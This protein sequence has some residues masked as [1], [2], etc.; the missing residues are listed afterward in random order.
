MHEA[1]RIIR[2]DGVQKAVAEEV[3]ASVVLS[4]NDTAHDDI[5]GI[6]RYHAVDEVGLPDIPVGLTDVVGHIE[7]IPTVG[8]EG[9]ELCD[10]AVDKLVVTAEDIHAV[11]FGV[12]DLRVAHP[13]LAVVQP[14]SVASHIVDDRVLQR[15]S[16]GVGVGA[17]A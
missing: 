1:H 12:A 7:R 17:V 6:T 13:G 8:G 11:T 4:L 9:I 10:G 16:G 5:V 3:R 15:E 2:L 14:Q